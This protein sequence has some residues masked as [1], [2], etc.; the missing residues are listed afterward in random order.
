VCTTACWL[1]RKSAKK[2]DYDLVNIGFPRFKK[3]GS[4]D[5]FR[6]P[7]P[8][9]IQLDQSNHRILLPKL[10]L[11]KKFIGSKETSFESNAQWAKIE[12]PIQG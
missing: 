11:V 5:S 6:Y 12:A 10:G 1:K 8:K 4:G 3:K 9:Q 2:L 7:E